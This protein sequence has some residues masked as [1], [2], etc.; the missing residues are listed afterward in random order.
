[1]YVCGAGF[2]SYTAGAVFTLLR[3]IFTFLSDNVIIRG[4]KIYIIFGI[5]KNN[6]RNLEKILKQLIDTDLPH[7]R[8]LFERQ[9]VAVIENVVFTAKTKNFRYTAHMS[10]R[11]IQV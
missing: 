3:Y 2:A 8:S 6:L 1:M 5:A 9:T 11:N 7:C 4:T 10:R